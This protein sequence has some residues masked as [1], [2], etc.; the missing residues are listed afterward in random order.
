MVSRRQFMFMGAVGGAAVI[1]GGA[2]F[3]I[4]D[5]YHGWIHEILKRW[6]PGYRFDPEGLALF[7]R[8]Y[9]KKQGHALKLR[10]FAAVEGVVDV[11]VLLPDELRRQVEEEERRVFSAF[12]VGSDFFDNYSNGPKTITYRGTPQA[13]GSPFATF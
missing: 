7:I 8:D 6:L 1:A 5:Q 10:T 3:A 13:C 12:L 2:A 4:T 11:K 9:N